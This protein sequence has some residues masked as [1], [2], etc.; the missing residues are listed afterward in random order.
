MTTIQWPTQGKIETYVFIFHY[1]LYFVSSLLVLFILWVQL[2]NDII[3]NL[4][5][6]VIAFLRSGGYCFCSLIQTWKIY[7]NT[8]WISHITVGERQTCCSQQV[9]HREQMRDATQQNLKRKKFEQFSA[10]VSKSF[11][12]FH[13]Q[14]CWI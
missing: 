10:P 12:S 8:D 2:W 3:E 1:P 13:V 5:V 11:T 7:F 14:L 6:F 4:C 9:Y